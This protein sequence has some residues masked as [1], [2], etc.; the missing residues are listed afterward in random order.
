MTET[1]PSG[2]VPTTPTEA[3]V[4]VSSDL[5]TTVVFGNWLVPGTLQVYKFL[6]LNGNGV[7]DADEPPMDVAIQAS[8]PC[9]QQISGS[10]GPDGTVAWPD[11]CVG[12]WT[13]TETV[14]SAYL[15]TRPTVVESDVHSGLTTTVTF[16]NWPIPGTLEVFKFEDRNGN[17]VQDAGEPPLAGVTINASSPCGQFVTGTTGADGYLRRTNRCV[18]VWIVS[19]DPPVH[20]VATT[21]PLA[22]TIV[23][24]GSTAT[25]RFGNRG[26]GSLAAHVFHDANLDGLQD[27]GEAD[28]GGRSLWWQNEYTETDTGTTDLS[29]DVLWGDVA[30]GQYSVYL[31][32]PLGCLVTTPA[33]AVITVLAGAT[34]QV[35]VGVR[36]D[37]YLPL[38]LRR[39][40]APTPTPTPTV[41][42]TPTLTPTPTSTPTNTPTPTRTP[43]P[44]PTATP[45]PTVPPEIPVPH[46]KAIGIDTR[47]NV[48]YV[49]SKTTASVYV[50]DGF[51]HTV[52]DIVAVGNDPFGLGVNPITRKAYVSNSADGTISVISM[53]T[54][55]VIA[56]IALGT[57]SQP[58]GI[59]VNPDTNRVLAA[60]HG[61]GE[62]A[63]IDGASGALITKVPVGGGPFGVVAD[64]LLNRAYVSTREGGYV[65]VVDGATNTEIVS[66]RTFV[67]GEAFQI[68]LDPALRRLYAVY[69]PSAMAKSD[70]LDPFGG[71]PTRFESAGDPNHIAVFEIKATGMGRI[72]NLMAGRAGV[73]GG[74]GIA[75]NLTTG[76]IFVSNAAENSLTVFHGGSLAAVATLPMPGA[77]GHVSANPLTNRVYVSNRSSN[78]V[79]M[80][81]DVW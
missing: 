12:T 61:T 62:L 54:R 50:I 42:P 76:D 33:P 7:Q 21:P 19:E 31:S 20:Y 37:V 16:G 77:P 80:V 5:T 17:G 41:T 45:L 71:D 65:A 44:T 2:H 40:P 60:L 53:D 56:T 48:L 11:L 74:V 4:S 28:L 59:G 35:E 46:P 3:T 67:G 24:S 79:Y 55:T 57:G 68:A 73:D 70:E 52:V 47:D 1:V 66:Q 75:A 30:A 63:V 39:H 36:C 58:L 8:S 26:L 38:L 69:A 49:A 81:E 32:T 15:A 9:G 25:V 27:P 22:S 51:T 18:G 64:P 78:S 13:V 34:A 14:P 10:T 29:G 72:T 23:T 43:T 6:D